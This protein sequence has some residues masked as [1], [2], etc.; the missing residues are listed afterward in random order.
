MHS[1]LPFTQLLNQL[2]GAPVTA[3]MHMLG[4]HPH[5]PTAPISN[6]MAMQILVVFV[7]LGVFAFVRTRLSVDAPGITQ[8]FV[9][10]L[11]G[12]I[13]GQ[14]E[15]V[16]GHHSERYTP[17][18]ASVFVYILAANLIGV[19]PFFESPTANPA[20]PL[21]LALSA[22]AFY[23]FQGIRK[24]GLRY[25][26]HFLG[27]VPLLAPLMLPI[28]IIS[29]CARAMSLTIRLYANIF[30]GDMVTLVFFSLVPIGLPVVFLGLHVGVSFLQAYIFTLLATVYLAG[31]V[32]EE[33]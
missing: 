4:L 5:D 20:V 12:F 25:L 18:L 6:W 2:I 21:G 14:S 17:F 15:E 27:P 9:E 13:G 24:Q 19:I 29:H 26:K 32:A 10:M 11:H 1:Q 16:I 3:V 7:L 23:H 33:H 31:A 28:E 22:W 30:A 8:H